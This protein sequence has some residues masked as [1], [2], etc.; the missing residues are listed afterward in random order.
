MIAADWRA[1]APAD[2]FLYL[3]A[4]LAAGVKACAARAIAPETDRWRD[5]DIRRA[6][7][8]MHAAYTGEAGRHFAPHGR[9]DEWLR[10]VSALVEEAPCGAI[11]LDSTRVVR[12]GEGLCGVALV[13][14]MHP[15][16]AHLAQLAVHPRCRRRGLATRLVTEAATQ[17]AAAGRDEMTLLVDE[18]NREARRLYETLGFTLRATFAR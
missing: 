13:T 12:D 15:N 7:A 14:F 11:D 3:S 10:Y 17:A 8:L 6:A 4:P 5:G 1:G 18:S 16:T 9:P 2:P